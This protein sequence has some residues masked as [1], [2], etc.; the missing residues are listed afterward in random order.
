[1]FFLKSLQKFDFQAVKKND[2]QQLITERE[3]I[4]ETRII[5]GT[6]HSERIYPSKAEIEVEMAN[7]CVTQQS[8]EDIHECVSEMEEEKIDQKMPRCVQRF[9]IGVWN[10]NT[11]T[12]YKLNVI[13]T[14]FVQE[15]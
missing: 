15:E 6:R 9:L 10:I 4:A 14:M 5:G 13:M 7:E 12:E 2:R 3:I 11:L 1:M 8:N